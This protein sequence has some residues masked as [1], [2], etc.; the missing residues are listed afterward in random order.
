MLEEL[1][2]LVVVRL[3][4][5]EMEIAESDGLALLTFMLK[6]STSIPALESNLF[7]FGEL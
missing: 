4:E 5:G 1:S 6:S 3:E 2:E 7:R